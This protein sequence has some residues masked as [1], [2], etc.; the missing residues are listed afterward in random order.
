[1][2]TFAGGRFDGRVA[3]VTG[4]GSGLGHATALRLAT[5]G[6]AVGCLDIA[7]D[8][9]EKTAAEI[10]EQGGDGPRVHGRR[11]RPRL[12]ARRG[13]RRAP[14]DL[15]RPQ[16]VV[17]CAGI[18]RFAHTHEVPFEDWQRIIGVNLTGTFL[19]CQAA[20]PHLLD[21]GGAI[22]NI[23]SNAGIKAQPYRAAYCASKAGVVHL[24]KVPRRRVPE[25]RHPRELRRAGRH[26]DAVAEGVHGDARR[27]RLEGVPQGDVAARQLARPRRSR[28]SSSFVASDECRY[29]TGVDRLDRRR[30]HGLTADRPMLDDARSVWELIERRAAASPDRVMLY[31]GDRDDDVRA[32]TRT[33]SSARPPGCTALGVGADV[34][35]SWQL[36]RGP[37]RR[38]SSARCA[39]SARCR[40]RCCRSTATARSR[41]SRSRPAASC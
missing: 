35:V 12:G 41:S 33:W 11:L 34:N 18:G 25:A 14:T 38:C 19:V 32:S 30:H 6:A 24:T 16:L 21:G 2:E 9:A 17:N 29:M 27:R 10:A 39:G 22:V 20:L 26:R 28:T 4:A 15:G 13:R 3:V 1:M 7:G 23:A 40:T 37:S 31:D 5:E 36:R 8:A